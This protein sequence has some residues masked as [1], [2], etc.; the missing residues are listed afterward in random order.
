MLLLLAG[1]PVWLVIAY[2]VAG[3]FFMPLLAALLLY[4]NNRR[5]WLG[6]MKN[7]MATNFILLLSVLVFGLLLY[8]EIGKQLG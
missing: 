8:T 7:G 6:G 1:K 4:M 3:A 2:A 5:D